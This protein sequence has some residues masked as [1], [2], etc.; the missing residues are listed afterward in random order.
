[1]QRVLAPA[2][3]KKG[4][5]A[6]NLQRKVK[7]P[8]L[9]YNEEAKQRE[10]NQNAADHVAPAGPDIT[11]NAEINHGGEH[12]R[13][14]SGKQNSNRAQHRGDEKPP[15]H[16]VDRPD[17]AKVGEERQKRDTPPCQI[18]PPHFLWNIALVEKC[19]D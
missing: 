8:A 19:L 1:M 12:Q 9:S 4:K 11:G 14:K 15:D 2:A 3:R 6:L 5:G 16:W 13:S 17:G 18:S 10:S 7:Q